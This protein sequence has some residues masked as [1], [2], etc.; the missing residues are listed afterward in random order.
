MNILIILDSIQIVGFAIFIFPLFDKKRIRAPWAKLVFL[1]ASIIGIAKAFAQLAMNFG[2]FTVSHEANQLVS[3][4]ISM[5]SGV[6]LGF[7]FALVFS[8]QLNGKKQPS[9]IAPEQTPVAP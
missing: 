7:I 3:D 2:L 1:L 5:A 9:I 4:Y 8:G 6:L